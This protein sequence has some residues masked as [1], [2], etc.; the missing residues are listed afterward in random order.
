MKTR[1]MLVVLAVVVAWLLVDRIRDT[2]QPALEQEVSSSLPEMR[3]LDPVDV[4]AYREMVSPTYRVRTTQD[5]LPGGFSAAMAPVMIDWKSTDVT[6]GGWAV[7]RNVNSG[8]NPISGVTVLRTMRL[9]P[10]MVK[11]AEFILVPLGGPKAV[12]HG[13]LRF[14]FEPGGAEFLGSADP[15]VGEPDVPTD[16]VISWEAWRPPGVDYSV[17]D[18]MDHN[19]YELSCRAYTGVQRFLE[20]ALGKRGWESY[21]LQL[22]GGDAGLA[23]LLKVALVLGDGAARYSIGQMLEMAE[24]EWAAAGPN[25]E[26]HGGNALAQWQAVWAQSAS[27]PVL[28]SDSRLDMRGR[29]GYQTLLRSCATMALYTVDVAVARLIEAG[30]PAGGKRPTQDPEILDEPEWMSELASTNLAG[31]FVRAPKALKWVVG[32]PHTVPSKMPA[33]LDE[34]GLLVHE[35]DKPRVRHYSMDGTTPWGPPEVLLIR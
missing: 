2:D 15:S 24:E 32:N 11:S 1:I 22:P 25:M 29:T 16:L 18:G 12:S 30:A 35:G 3:T 8:G 4:L 13:Q 34:A 7:I 5:V 31:I 9:K 23:T 27:N 19:V 14:E 28:D 6:E 10:D 17:L 33:A 26:T 21:T 20:D